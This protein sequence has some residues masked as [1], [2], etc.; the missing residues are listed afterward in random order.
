MTHIGTLD[1]MSNPNIINL[2]T[3]NI[4]DELPLI[5]A[6]LASI[7]IALIFW[8]RAAA[9][10]LY[11]VLGFG[12]M[13]ALCLLYPFWYAVTSHLLAVCNPQLRRT[14][15]NV[16]I[17]SWSVLKAVAIILLLAAVYAGRRQP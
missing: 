9:A 13:V 8:R 4:L 11:A 1:G 7:V 6:C 17:L 16:F 14:V 12:L 15:L 5:A 3:C 2:I 10:S